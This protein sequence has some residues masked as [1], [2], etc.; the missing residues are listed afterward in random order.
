MKILIVLTTLLVVTVDSLE[1][2]SSRGTQCRNT[3]QG[4][5]H[6]AD[7]RGYVCPLEELIFETGCCP[8]VEENRY[9]CASCEPLTQCCKVYEYCVSCCLSPTNAK[10]RERAMNKMKDKRTYQRA[11]K[12]KDVFEFCRASCRTSSKSTVHGNAY[13]SEYRHCVS[14][15]DL[16]VPP[17]LKAVAGL[18]GQS[19][20]DT[21]Q[22]A[23]LACDLRFLFAVNT[24]PQMEAAFPCPGKCKENFGHDQP[25]YVSSEENKESYGMCL[26]NS[27]EAY[28]SCAGSHKHTR[29]L[30]PCRPVPV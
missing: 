17:D 6:F 25:A 20:D 28:Y 1:P 26:V 27:K 13:N 21:C 30:C 19:C 24:C 22:E 4:P 15:D 16:G 5:Y 11:V 12:E 29:R 2:I 7:D 23:G 9:S 14:P 3:V 10:L 18:Q 8:D